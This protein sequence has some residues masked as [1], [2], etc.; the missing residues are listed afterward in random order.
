MAGY[1]PVIVISHKQDQV[2]IASSR[3]LIERTSKQPLAQDASFQYTWGKMPASAHTK[4]YLSKQTLA[5][6]HHF[7]LL[8]RKENW[9][10]LEL[11]LWLKPS[12]TSAAI[13]QLN[14]KNCGLAF[15]FD[16]SETCDTLTLQCALP[17]QLLTR[18]MEK[19]SQ[20]DP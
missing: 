14:S 13:A 6:I 19:T 5:T 8:A 10:Q 20:D 3:D 4:C 17:L 18:L 1:L 15:S 2:T 16:S 7:Y 12:T 9:M 11:P